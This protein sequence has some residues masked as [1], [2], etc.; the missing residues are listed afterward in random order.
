MKKL[1]LAGAT[2]I[3]MGLALHVTYAAGP[4]EHRAARGEPAVSRSG[5]SR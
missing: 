5:Q 1:M 4:A 3:V 2:A